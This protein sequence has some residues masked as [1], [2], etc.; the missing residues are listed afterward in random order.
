MEFLTGM[1]VVAIVAEFVI[2]LFSKGDSEEL[3]KYMNSE[4][5]DDYISRPVDYHAEK[6]QLLD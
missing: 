5:P 4:H 1:V 6:W 3:Y 2:E